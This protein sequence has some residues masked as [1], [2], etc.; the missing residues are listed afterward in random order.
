MNEAD[1]T[2]VIKE[3]VGAVINRVVYYCAK[4]EEAINIED[5]EVRSWSMVAVGKHVTIWHTDD[6]NV[7]KEA[8]ELVFKDSTIKPSK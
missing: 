1:D 2:I 8:D 6:Y 5:A 7:L 3:F 4:C